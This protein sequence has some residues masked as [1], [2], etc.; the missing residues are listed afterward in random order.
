MVI[1]PEG[2][3]LSCPVHPE[4]HHV[5]GSQPIYMESEPELRLDKWE[6]KTGKPSYPAKWDSQ[7]IGSSDNNWRR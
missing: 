4:G 1:P 3:H 7:I 6:R 2:V 5:F